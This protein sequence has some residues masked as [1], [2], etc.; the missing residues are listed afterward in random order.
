MCCVQHLAQAAQ[1]CGR[2]LMHGWCAIPYHLAMW[3]FHMQLP[4]VHSSLLPQIPRHAT[5]RHRSCGAGAPAAAFRSPIRAG[6]CEFSFKDCSAVCCPLRVVLSLCIAAWHF[7]WAQLLAISPRCE[8]VL[9]SSNTVAAAVLNHDI[10]LCRCGQGSG[11]RNGQAGDAS[12]ILFFLHCCCQV[13]RWA[14][15]LNLG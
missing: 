9:S 10:V 7:C 14:R 5:H 3:A 2:F 6:R 13:M 12:L 11:A 15:C 8:Q 4:C 1:S